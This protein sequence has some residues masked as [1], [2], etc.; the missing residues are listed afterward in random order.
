M[1][2]A[3]YLE[4]I[5]V[6]LNSVENPNILEIGI[7]DGRITIPMLTEMINN[8]HEFF[9]YG[10]DIDIKDKISAFG[11]DNGGYDINF[12]QQNSLVEMP[13][14]AESEL[15]FDLILIDGDHNY[16]TVSKEL[17]YVDKLLHDNSILIVDD[18]YGPWATKDY[19]YWDDK[20]STQTNNPLATTKIDSDK[21]GVLTAVLDWLDKKDDM[22]IYSSVFGGLIKHNRD[23]EK[24]IGE[25]RPDCHGVLIKNKNFATQGDWV[26]PV[27]KLVS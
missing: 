18:F 9:Y 27:F 25:H 6:F 11:L 26:S 7:E 24:Q 21:Q 17:T 20:T 15:K 13:K 22:E 12:V 3:A 14:L 10:I 4:T 16:H 2:Y 5:N 19:W 23:K 8:E 1:A